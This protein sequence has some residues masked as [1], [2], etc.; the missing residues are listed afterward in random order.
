MQVRSQRL[1][2][3][4]L[5]E[6]Q[7]ALATVVG[8]M[9]TYAEAVYAG[10]LRDTHDIMQA[11]LGRL[12]GASAAPTQADVEAHL[13]WRYAQEAARADLAANELQAHRV[14][15]FAASADALL[16]AHT[17]LID[18][19]D[20]LDGASRLAQVDAFVSKVDAMRDDAAA[21]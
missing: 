16:A 6:N 1:A 10:Q 20:K 13:P 14:Q 19:F 4:T 8:A 21:L 18:N 12:V 3:A 2:R 7:D 9:K 15:A 11:E 5:E 17:A